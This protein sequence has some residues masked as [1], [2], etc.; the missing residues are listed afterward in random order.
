MSDL[1]SNISEMLLRYLCNLSK[2][3][4]DMIF[5]NEYFCAC[6]CEI[7][8]CIAK[9]YNNYWLQYKCQLNEFVAVFPLYIYY[10]PLCRS[11]PCDVAT[12]DYYS[13]SNLLLYREIVYRECNVRE[14]NKERKKSWPYIHLWVFLGNTTLILRHP[15]SGCNP[16]A[17]IKGTVNFQIGLLFYLQ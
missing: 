5:Y 16:H 6:V 8:L 4:C 10:Q 17:S 12:L 9:S 7:L 3:F 13:Y 2:A 11:L 1:A 15:S 14:Q